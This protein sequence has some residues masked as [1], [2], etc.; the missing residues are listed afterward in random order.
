MSGTQ[1]DNTHYE[2]EIPL[3]LK[4]NEKISAIPWMNLSPET[5]TIVSF[6]G[7]DSSKIQTYSLLGWFK[8]MSSLK[9]VENLCDRSVDS[10]NI[11]YMSETFSGCNSL[12]GLINIDVCF[13]PSEAADASYC[14][15]GC[16]NLTSI[17]GISPF[18]SVQN[19]QSLFEERSK[20]TQIDLSL[21]NNSPISNAQSMFQGVA[22]D[23]ELGLNFS[24]L[25]KANFSNL[26]YA[27]SMF[28]QA[29]LS[30]RNLS[31]CSFASLQTIESMFQG[32]QG[33]D[34]IVFNRSSEA[35]AVTNMNYAFDSCSCK[36]INISF[37]DNTQ[38]TGTV[39]MKGAFK[40]CQNL[41]RIIVDTN[42]WNINKV[43]N[44]D[45]TF[46]NCSV[47]LAG[48]AVDGTSCK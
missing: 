32:T 16:S 40:G 43:T 25:S 15:K 41:T 27:S 8:G 29:K 10:S 38:L 28:I 7:D 1:K 2:S 20:L 34:S 35:S 31:T 46:S 33:I 14:F 26:T 39:S 5:I 21:F 23:S 44:Y 6:F 37:I 9:N 47:K 19:A 42:K 22:V 30:N 3:Y 4:D 45:T 17:A 24:E 48:I 36:R 12:Q 13:T 11:K 18:K